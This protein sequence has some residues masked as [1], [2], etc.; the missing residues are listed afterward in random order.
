MVDIFVKNSSKD[1]ISFQYYPN[2]KGGITRG[3]IRP[4]NQARYTLRTGVMTRFNMWKKSAE[5]KPDLVY[6]SSRVV[7]LNSFFTKRK[8]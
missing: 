2:T 4:G 3:S 1:I 5:R 7:D 6:T 8:S